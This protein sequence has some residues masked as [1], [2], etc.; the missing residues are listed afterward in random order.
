MGPVWVLDITLTADGHTIAAWR[1]RAGREPVPADYDAASVAKGIAVVTVSGHGT[2]AKSVDSQVAARVREDGATFL[3]TQSAGQLAFVRHERLEPLRAALAAAGIRPQVVFVGTSPAETAQ[4]WR[5]GLRWRDPLRLTDEGSALAQALVRRSALPVLGA[6]LGLLF[7]NA[8]AAPRLN[9]RRQSLQ[10]EVAAR[11]RTA[12][13]VADATGR[14]RALLAEFGARPVVSRAVVC[15]RIAAAVPEKVVLTRLAVE[16]LSKRFEAGKPLQRQ[17]RTAVVAGTA[18]TA[19]EVS[20]FVE[21]LTEEACCRTVR[22]TNV[23][24]ERG[25]ERLVFHI[26][27]GL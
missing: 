2:I 5:A 7:A 8:L 14:Q 18:P 25:A 20:A 11:E 9:A 19:G 22:L 13:T 4:R 3:A 12:S 17:E 15:D 10:A 27:I 23:E 1:C 21:R 26:E 6:V 24:R 16:P